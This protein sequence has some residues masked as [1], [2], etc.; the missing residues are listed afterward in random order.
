METIF[1]SI[2]PTPPLFNEL[3]ARTVFD[4]LSAHIAIID[5]TG[6][7]IETNAAWRDFGRQNGL[8]EGYE[9]MGKNYLTIC[10]S[11]GGED[12][13]AARKIA[14]GIRKVAAGEIR[15]FRKDYPCHS[16]IRQYWYY[17][18][19][20][21]I[22]GESPVRLIISHEDITELKLAEE[23]LRQSREESET[24][25][26]ELEE[27]NI[28]LKVLLK[29]RELDKVDLEKRV[30]SN[31]KELVFPY[32][33]KLKRSSLR[34]REKT[35]INIVS[36]HLNDIISPFMQ[37]L[38]NVNVL[39]TPQETQVAMLV[40]DGKTSQEIS[41]IL[42]ISEATV[43]FHRKNVRK[44]LGIGNKTGNLRS[45]LMSLAQ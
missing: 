5:E 8:P 41:D 18:R 4:A 11:T 33:E 32:I 26:Q 20:V 12:A 23:A 35:F 14:D 3:Q 39:L 24:R 27:M 7:I 25:R 45:F 29:Q 6:F 34:Q 43:G 15:E 28:A 9:A 37:R 17:L 16:A 42:N 13:P 30:L 21:R 22:T 2:C 1:G 19:A 40:K 44:K 36:E 31:I 38:S 10:D